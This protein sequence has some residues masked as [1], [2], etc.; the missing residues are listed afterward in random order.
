M[1][2]YAEKILERKKQRRREQL[3][4]WLMILPYL[5]IFIVFTV[6]P[7]VMGT[8]FSFMRYN[9]YDSTENAFFGFQNYI[10]IFNFSLPISKTFWKSFSTMLL[11]DVICVPIL[12]V[13]SL[14]IAYFVNKKPP[15][16]KF[17]RAI[18]FLP[19]V[20]SV[21]V[22]GVIFGNMFASNRSGLFNAWFGTE[23]DWLGGIPFDGDILRWVVIL[24]V[25]LW[26]GV[27]TNFIIFSGAM[28]DVPKSLYE[29]CE[30]D[31]GNRWDL[32]RFVT[33]PNIRG[34]IALTLFNTLIAYLGLYGQPTVLYTMENQG[35]LVS[36]LMF[37]QRYLTS[38]L[39]YAR[40]TGYLCACA[41]VFGIIVAIIS[42][43]QRVAMNDRR[44]RTDHTERC[45]LYLHSRGGWAT[46]ACGEC[47]AEQAGGGSN[48]ND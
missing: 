39:N 30:M 44:R 40:Q 3:A 33:I 34:A 27:G 2:E 16:Y 5:L 6:V 13:L 42:T 12:M 15:L 28:R 19:S 20:I 31:G 1:D 37:I 18:I 4:A 24:I 29:A 11:F 48:E 43:I 23:I 17:F 14:L 7:V 36:P 8:G 26:W 45:E 25:S 38:G 22:T 46:Y 35:E 32:V 21:S 10:N 41:I 9:P 47:C